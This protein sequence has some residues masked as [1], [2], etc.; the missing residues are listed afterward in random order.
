MLGEVISGLMSCAEGGILRNATSFDNV[1]VV[2]HQ[3]AVFA[4]IEELARSCIFVQNVCCC[5]Q[6]PE[7][8]KDGLEQLVVQN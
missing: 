8:E 6:F 2:V 5:V 1:P 7:I 4:G 3:I